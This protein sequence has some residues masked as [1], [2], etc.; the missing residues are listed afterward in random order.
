MEWYPIDTAPT[1]DDAPEILLGNYYIDNCHGYC[2]ESRW[3]WI[4][5]GQIL[6]SGFW[7]NFND[8]ERIKEHMVAYHRPT[9]WT[10]L[11]EAPAH[12]KETSDIFTARHNIACFLLG[13]NILP[14]VHGT[15]R[16]A[17]IDVCESKGYTLYFQK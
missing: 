12:T 7:C 2:G 16:S 1:G 17:A 4:A 5:Q 3:I 6:D 14:H 13:A 8:E 10:Y 11:P 15:R 9:H